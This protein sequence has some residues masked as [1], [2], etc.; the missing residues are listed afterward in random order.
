MT[1][2]FFE[3]HLKHRYF[4][5]QAS[6]KYSRTVQRVWPGQSPDVVL[7]LVQTRP[8]IFATPKFDSTPLHSKTPLQ[9]S[10]Q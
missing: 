1:P 3:G 9:A 4:F 7:L 10:T 6:S 2:I 8:V 5:F